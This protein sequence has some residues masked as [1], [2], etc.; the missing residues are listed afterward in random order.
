MH[1]YRQRLSFGIVLEIRLN[2]IVHEMRTHSVLATVFYSGQN[3]LAFLSQLKRYIEAHIRTICDM[4]HKIVIFGPKN[5]ITR[6]KSMGIDLCIARNDGVMSVQGVG[7]SGAKKKNFLA[8]KGS[9][10]WK[11]LAILG[12]FEVFLTLEACWSRNRN[13]FSGR[14]LCVWFLVSF[15]KVI[16]CHNRKRVCIGDAASV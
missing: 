11:I 7:G 2:K 14:W 16:R 1:R 8:A 5:A 15:V 4:W 13:F 12:D 3:G 9:D 10:N 6:R